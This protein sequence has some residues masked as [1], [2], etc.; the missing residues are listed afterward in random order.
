MRKT[1][2][3]L[4]V[5]ID[6]ITAADALENA[7]ALLNSEG[8]S[9][10]F[11]P[12]PEFIMTARKDE[13]F[14]RILNQAD[15]CTP[16]GIGVVYAAKILKTPVQERVAGFDLACSLLA[17]IAGTGD[18]VFLFGAKPGVAERAAENLKKDYPGLIISGTHNGYF[19]PEEDAD[20][21]QEINNSGAKL[22]LV[23][24]GAPKQERWIDAHRAELRPSLCM[25]VGGAL[26][27]LA[28]E[29]KRAPKLF[30]RFNL[31]W[32]YRLLKQPSRIGRFM[33]LPKF[34][35]IVWKNRKKE[36][37]M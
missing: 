13:D 7:K 30:I 11:T 26:D 33:A 6:N 22:L 2:N 16:D 4:G 10:I 32:L 14:R 5:N 24:L 25:G 29:V 19:Q 27:V 1:V 21:V 12:N 37:T 20:I 35:M 23:C 34:I 31:E 9:R 3:I 17:H 18:G 8:V 28:G 36:R 15:M